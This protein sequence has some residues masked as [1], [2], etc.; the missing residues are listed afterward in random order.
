MRQLK[1]IIEVDQ[2]L[3]SNLPP[4]L[5]DGPTGSG[6]ST[7]AK[8]IHDNGPRQE[9]PFVAINC[10]AIPDNL[11]ESELFGHEKGAFTDAKGAR[12]GLFEAADRGTLFLDEI[13]SLSHDAQSK[14]LLTIE[15]GLI[16]RIGGNNEIKV[17]VRIIGAANQDLRRLIAEGSFREDLFHRLDLLRVNIPP[18]ESRGNDVVDLANHLLLSLA[19]KYNVEK[20]SIDPD[21]IPSLTSYPWPGNTRELIH[22]LERALVMGEPNQS[23]KLDFH[24]TTQKIP[25]NTDWLNQSFLFPD[26]GFDLENEILR[27]IELAIKQC[28]GN[29]SE[30]ARKLGVPRDYI[31][32][33]KKKKED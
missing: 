2:R 12:I 32:Y 7:Y 20:P 10:S 31:R 13:S 26:S 14:L 18:L 1:R 22:E 24:H 6:K 5:I 30:A 23:L 8:W 29:V 19:R 9:A 27:L 17:D 16:R 3:L 25:A 4:V 15:N 28:D 21:S 11:V 33:R